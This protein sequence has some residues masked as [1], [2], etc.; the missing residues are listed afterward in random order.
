MANFLKELF[1]RAEKKE[2]SQQQI[3]GLQQQYDEEYIRYCIELEQTVSALEAYLHTSDDPKEIAIQTLKTACDFYGGDWAGILEVDLE[4]DVWT[5]VWW[6]NI[7][8]TDRTLQLMHEFEV[9]QFMPSWIQAMQHNEPIILPDI[10]VIKNTHPKEYEVYQRLRVDSVIATSFAPNPIGFLAIRNPKRY[11]NRPSM[12]NILAYVLH[13]AMAQQKTMDSA[14]MSLSPEAIQSDKDIIINFFGSMEICTSK[15]ILREQD[16]KSPKSSRVATYLML[17][18]RATHPPLEISSALW[19]DDTSD[20]DALASN[21]RGLIYRFRQAFSL[22]SE[23]QLIESTPNG[24]RI[25]PD[26]HIMTDLQQFDMLWESAQ[27]AG[28]T[29]QRVELLKQAF[30]LYR[31]PVFENASGEHWIMALTTHYSLRY[32]GLVNELLAALAQ[33]KDYAGLQ[34]YAARAFDIMPNNVKIRYWIIYAMYHL[35]AVEMAKGEVAHAKADLSAEEYATL[36]GYLKEGKE[37]PPQ[38]LFEENPLR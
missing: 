26:L 25:N 12:M 28:V 38:E 33:G 20:P 16:F 10:S 31:G 27:K 18:R 8:A 29:S 32:V 5:P 2:E 37:L 35:G 6:Y 21:I 30:N 34:L 23:Y 11:I 17:H 3:C 13:R 36:V 4:L 22:V 7:N 24:Y 9:A 1:G 15:G 19:P 14:R